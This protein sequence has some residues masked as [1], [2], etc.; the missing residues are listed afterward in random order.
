M[1]AIKFRGKCLHSG[2]WCFGNLVNYGDGKVEIQG[3]DVYHENK[4]EWQQIR[5]SPDTV[6]QFTGLYDANN[7]RIYEG[8]L[9]ETC[10]MLCE[11]Q[12]N[13]VIAAFVLT[14]PGFGQSMIAAGKTLGLYRCAIVGNIQDSRNY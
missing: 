2:K 13:C 7:K 1:R 9:V 6:E 5:V 12:Y 8:D 11:V 3:F 10:G 14:K 4:D